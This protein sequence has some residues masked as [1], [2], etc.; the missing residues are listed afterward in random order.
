[1][2][3]ETGK[4]YV[5]RTGSAQASTRSWCLTMKPGKE[6]KYG[7]AL[8]ASHLYFQQETR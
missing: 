3:L 2:K 7:C 5:D 4:R 1:M 6:F 8:A